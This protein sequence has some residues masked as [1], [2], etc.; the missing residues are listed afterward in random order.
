MNS[1]IG[2]SRVMNVSS[3][4]TNLFENAKPRWSMFRSRLPSHNVETSR[5]PKDEVPYSA[6]HKPPPPSDSTNI[7]EKHPDEDI[8]IVECP[9]D[10]V[11]TTSKHKLYFNPEYLEP[12]MLMVR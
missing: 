7:E 10:I 12:E 1:T 4:N 9:E 3:Q 11:Q 2:E 8:S 6:V 5:E